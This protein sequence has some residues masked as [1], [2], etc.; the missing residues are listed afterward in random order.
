MRI[1]FAVFVLFLLLIPELW[2]GSCGVYLPLAWMGFF[3]FDN[4]GY[5]RGFL[6]LT[7]MVGALTV[8]LVLFRRMFMPDIFLLFAVMFLAMRYR[9]FWRGSIWR[10]GIFAFLLLPLSYIVQFLSALFFD[11]FSWGSFSAMAAQMTALSP[12]GFILLAGLAVLL[13]FI[14]KKMQLNS[15]FVVE[16][17][18]VSNAVYHKITGVKLHD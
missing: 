14:Q 7:G 18:N 11:S 3:Y 5:P 8:D 6:L 16:K 2:I 4:A 10:G 17:D 13:D 9:E 12:V 1:F 15:P